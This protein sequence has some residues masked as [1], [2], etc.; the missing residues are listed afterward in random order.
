VSGLLGTIG[1]RLAG[2]PYPAVPDVAEAGEVGA[3]EL[4]AAAGTYRLGDGALAV[5]V[6]GRA[7]V[8]EAR[9]AQAF[10]RLHGT[11]SLDLARSERLS[12]RLDEIVT[13]F[14]H[15][16]FTPMA[17]AYGGEVPVERLREVWTARLREIEAEKGKL[18]DHEV[19]GTAAEAERDVTV[20]R[21]RFEKGTVER[22]FV[23]DK[24]AP[25]RLRGVSQRGLATQVRC[26]P[27]HG[28]GF[29][30]WDPRT[31][32]SRPLR[33]EPGAQGGLRLHYGAGEQ[34]LTAA[35]E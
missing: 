18:K 34:E 7:L 28:G 11:R 4:A 10:S 16:D 9:G 23:W 13:G 33:F 2:V 21:L 5:R 29:A 22:A 26:V 25:E 35:R 12:R 1:Q 8:I 27:V 20:V 15:G 19:L 14:L 32:D 17:A 24:D 30:S 3:R 6:D 31:G